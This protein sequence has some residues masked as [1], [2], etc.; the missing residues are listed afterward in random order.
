MSFISGRLRNHLPWKILRSVGT[1]ILL[2]KEMALLTQT[3]LTDE[4]LISPMGIILPKRPYE[5]TKSATVVK[6]YELQ[7]WAGL[8]DSAAGVN[9][10]KRA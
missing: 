6:C 3:P 9:E 10:E 7:A 8:Y 4:G 5:L 1:N 2:P